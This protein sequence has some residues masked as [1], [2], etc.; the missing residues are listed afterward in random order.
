MNKEENVD[1]TLQYFS[2]VAQQF[3]DYEIKF[4]GCIRGTFSAKAQILI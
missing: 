2:E 3:T 1:N 4:C